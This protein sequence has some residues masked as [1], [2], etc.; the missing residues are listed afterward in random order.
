MSVRSRRHDLRVTSAL[1]H[2]IALVAAILALCLVPAGVAQAQF[3][4]PN[5]PQ[6]LTTP[7]P[8]PPPKAQKFDDGGISTLQ[9]VLIFGGAT[10]VLSL[11]AFVI[12]R[13]ARRAA[14]VDERP[15]RDGAN[16]SHAKAGAPGHN[17][18]MSEIRARERAQAKRA[19]AKARNVRQQRKKNRPR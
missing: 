8:P 5:A 19:K 17:S 13:D 14:P 3:G 10:L 16:P 4:A 2:R 18:S 7:P 6:E 9:T 12:V 1:M 11:I 15:R